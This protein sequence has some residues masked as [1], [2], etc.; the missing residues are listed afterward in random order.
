[1]NPTP[2]LA[3]FAGSAREGS[4]NKNLA[5]IA[6]AGATEAGAEGRFL[7][8]REYPLPVYDQEREEREGIPDAARELR[9]I[10]KE[11]DGFLIAS[12]EHNSSISAM[13]KNVI[14]WTSRAEGDDPGLI[15]FRGKTACLMSASPGGLGGLRGL[16]H[17]RAILSNIGVLVLPGQQA[18]P[19]AMNAFDD[20]GQLVDEDMN[21]SIRGLG[22]DLAVKTAKL[23]A[24]D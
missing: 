6:L 9:R 12:P 4:Y 14:D 18:V 2:K 7:D 8:L 21:A 24:G 3:A 1:M 19:G 20:E 11:Q 22:R 23:I 16:V 17:V 15:A 5:R 10:L 13:L